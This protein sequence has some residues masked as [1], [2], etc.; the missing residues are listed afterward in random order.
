MKYPIFIHESKICMKR[1]LSGTLCRYA[2]PKLCF[3]GQM[4]IYESTYIVLL[5]NEFDMFLFTNCI[6]YYLLIL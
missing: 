2:G 6:M 1:Y 5:K 3:R 4:D